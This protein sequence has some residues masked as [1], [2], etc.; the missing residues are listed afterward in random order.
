[1]N[2]SIG[3]VAFSDKRTLAQIDELLVQ[4]GIRRDPNLDYLCAMFDEDFN[5]LATGGCFGNT[6]RCLAVARDHQGEGLLN[7][8]V[9]HLIN[10]QL[11]RGNTHWFLYTKC[12]AA[13][14]FQ[15][16]SFYEIVR[17][18]QQIVFMENKR[19][20]FADYLTR[21]QQETEQSAVENGIVFHG[22][23]IAAIV[24]NANPFTLGHQY[25]LEKA[26]RE[27]DLV[28]LFMVS[29]DS[30]L[31]PYAVRKKLIEAGI[32]HLPNVVLH[33]SGS[34]MISQA[35]FP[36]YFQKNEDAVI[37][38]HI[39]I[40]LQIFARIAQA[41]GITRRYVGDEPFSHVTQ[42]YNQAMQQQLPQYGVQCVVVA[43]KEISER[44]IS[45]S[46][47][48]QAIK[49]ENW[50]QVER[51]V[52]PTTFAFLRSDEALPIINRIRQTQEVKHY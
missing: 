20:G 23:N 45:A 40:D 48:R 35:T 47:V 25:L 32:A 44:A 21:L 18:P 28:H 16:L 51:L 11:E 3:Q 14:F 1:M 22:R 10:I 4:E 30:S 42:L 34:Y 37:Q 26:A 29:E 13:K 50:A 38:S 5:V 19:H 24:M 52:P 8:I 49:D 7:Q 27:N 46:E 12:E 39:E 9:T 41:L 6:L 36:S 33:E 31:F 15:D 2:Y 17:I 43:R